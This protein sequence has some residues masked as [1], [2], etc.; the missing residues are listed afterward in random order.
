MKKMLALALALLMLGIGAAMA[1]STETAVEEQPQEKT[2]A[3]SSSF[4]ITIELPAGY[5]M[6]KEISDG[7]LYAEIFSEETDVSY[8]LAVAYS[9]EL[10]EQDDLTKMT[11]EQFDE[12]VSII[13]A[14]YAAPETRVYETSH[15]TRL[16]FIH[17]TAAE[18]SGYGMLMT[19][20]Q[21]YVIGLYMLDTVNPLSEE[22]IQTGVDMLSE[23][24][25]VEK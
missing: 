15:G 13:A 25:F 4:D 2:L 16:L 14:D 17:E 24:W 20:Y 7:F 19:V 23:L 22:E 9:E 10:S 8:T 18:E 12:F 6:T 21:N 1:E 11:Q 3:V 5:Q